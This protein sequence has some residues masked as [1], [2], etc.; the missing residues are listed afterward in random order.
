MTEQTPATP[1]AVWWS[2]TEKRFFAEL[3]GM[4]AILAGIWRETGTELPADAVRLVPEP[5]DA[6][7]ELADEI[8]GEI[9]AASKQ[10]EAQPRIGRRVL[11]EWVERIRAASASPSGDTGQ[12]V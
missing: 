11:A 8:A 9:S 12:G 3:W 4:T 7:R 1:P 5:A 6:L 2:P 10:G